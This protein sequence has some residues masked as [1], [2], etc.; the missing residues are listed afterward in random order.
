MNAAE[1]AQ[2]KVEELEAKIKQAKALAAQ[3][4]ARANARAQESTT[5]IENRRK[6]LIG[7]MYFERMKNDKEASAAIMAGLDKFLTRKDERELFRLG[8][9][10]AAPAV[11][12]AGQAVATHQPLF[13]AKTS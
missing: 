6:I 7:A 3:I 2:K 1:K 13:A 5:K 12:P 8:P 11:A 9:K 10:L 4:Q